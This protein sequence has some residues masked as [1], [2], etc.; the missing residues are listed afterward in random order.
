M[1]PGRPCQFLRM[2]A[3][4]GDIG[5][6]GCQ[7]PGAQDTEAPVAEYHGPLDPCEGHLLQD[8]A[9]GRKGLGEGRQGIRHAGRHL[10]E[11]GDGQY[12]VIGHAPVK[13]QDSQ[14]RTLGAV[15]LQPFATPLAPAA[16]GVDFSDHAAPCPGRVGTGFHLPDELVTENPL[17]AH[18]AFDDLQVG[19]ANPGFRILT[20]TQPGEASGMGRSAILRDPSKTTA[21]IVPPVL[22]VINAGDL[23]NNQSS[24]PFRREPGRRFVSAAA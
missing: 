16:G 24:A 5:Q 9:G 18:V 21:R 19:F 14:Y 7:G 8:F 20:R 12:A 15:A 23:F 2:L 6:D 1:A 11:V 17:K 3:H 13:G 22:R 10:A 4:Q